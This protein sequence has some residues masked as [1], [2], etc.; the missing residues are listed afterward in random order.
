MIYSE[1]A[2]DVLLVPCKLLDVIWTEIS[3]CHS[4]KYLPPKTPEWQKRELN[5]CDVFK[6]IACQNRKVSD[7][8]LSTI[9]FFVLSCSTPYM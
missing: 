6:Q 2:A 3:I 7:E 4:L 1:L 5:S 8:N 9:F